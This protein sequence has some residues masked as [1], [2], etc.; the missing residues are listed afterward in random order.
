MGRSR[1]NCKRSSGAA[2]SDNAE[3]KNLLTVKKIP[4]LPKANCAGYSLCYC[5]EYAASRSNALN[6]N[7]AL[8]NYK[9][10]GLSRS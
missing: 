2:N 1:R 5:P 10:A 9:S 8:L 4:G 6:A 3:N 7:R